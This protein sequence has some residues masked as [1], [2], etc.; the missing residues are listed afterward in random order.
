MRLKTIEEM[1]QLA[2]EAWRDY[3]WGEDSNP[4]SQQEAFIAA[5]KAVVTAVAESGVHWVPPELPGRDQ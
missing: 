2:H 1:G 3:W 5:A 4:K